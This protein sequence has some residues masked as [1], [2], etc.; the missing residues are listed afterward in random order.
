MD[1]KLAYINGIF[2]FS[3]ELGS[4]AT[5]DSLYTAVIISL[6]TDR[7]ADA[8]DELP[9]NSADRRGW[10]GDAYAEVDGDLVGSHLWLLGRE[11]QLPATARRAEKYAADALQWLV[12]D[13]IAK[14]VSTAAEWIDMGVLALQGKIVRPDGTAMTFRFNNLWE[15]INAV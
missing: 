7:L 12:D 6:F 4:L 2:D 3:V 14:S 9:D 1:A 13:G 8:G 5:D 15:A 11:K 10:W